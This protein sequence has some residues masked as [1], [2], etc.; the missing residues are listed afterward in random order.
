M[1]YRERRMPRFEGILLAVSLLSIIAALWMPE[2]VGS[3]RS[4][5]TIVG[6]VIYYTAT[7]AFLWHALRRPRADRL[8]LAAC[9]L[10][11]VLTSI[12]D[13]LLFYGLIRSSV[14]L[15]AFTSPL[16]LIGMG[17]VLAYRFAVAS[18]AASSEGFISMCVAERNRRSQC[19][20]RSGMTLS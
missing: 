19:R 18:V 9:M 12:H 14:Y 13:F 20:S 8:V 4:W 16:T 15:L 6:G 5:W 2:T 11:Q 3:N 1:R 7:L 10:V 17:F